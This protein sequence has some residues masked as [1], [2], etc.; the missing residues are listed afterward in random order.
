[1]E[2][3]TFSTR[4][5]GGSSKH[6]RKACR[7]RSGVGNGSRCSKGCDRT[8]HVHRRARERGVESYRRANLVGDDI[9]FVRRGKPDEPRFDAAHE[10]SLLGRDE[11]VLRMHGIEKSRTRPAHLL[12]I[13]P[14]REERGARDRG[15][16]GG[17]GEAEKGRSEARREGPAA[18]S[19]RT[20]TDVALDARNERGI[21]FACSEKCGHDGYL[22]PFCI[23]PCV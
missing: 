13:A 21:H 4:E 10:T 14:A 2:R 7:R 5:A 23:A 9:A 8:A 3:T 18:R 22:R 20:G 19:L 16:A 17:N 1:L 6:D 12:L 15:D 11:R